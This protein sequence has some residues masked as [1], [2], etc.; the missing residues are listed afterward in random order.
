MKLLVPFVHKHLIRSV[1][2]KL[3]SPSNA[4]IGAPYLRQIAK[5]WVCQH[6]RHRSQLSLQTHGPF[7]NTSKGK[8]D[9]NNGLKSKEL[10]FWILPLRRVYST[11]QEK[12]EIEGQDGSK[13]AR[14]E[15][16]SHEE[17]RR[18]HVAKRFS[19]VMD[20][21]QTNIFVAG[22]RLND[23]TGYSGIEALKKEIEEQGPLSSM[24]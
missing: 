11:S 23:L 3:L 22:Q 12:L 7:R 16:P 1:P 15:L 14:I 13:A 19:H 24:L 2:V 6:C 18:S 10:T 9:Q 4:F 21:L 20:N 8:H 17:G 5:P